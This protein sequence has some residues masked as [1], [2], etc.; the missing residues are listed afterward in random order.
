[1]I[2]S[3]DLPPSYR[4]VLVRLAQLTDAEAGEV[5]DAL[6][7]TAPL[8]DRDRLLD[9]LDATS[10]FADDGAGGV[11]DAL[12]GIHGLRSA[13]GWGIDETARA[14][15]WSLDDLDDAA[16][17][18]LVAR[19]VRAL[20]SEGLLLTSK[21]LDV[22]TDHDRVYLEAR[23]LTDLRPVFLDDPTSGIQA[24]VIVHTLRINHLVDGAEASFYVA[25]DEAD[26]EDLQ[27]TLDR[28][29]EKA[30]HLRGFAA[31]A[32][33]DLYQPIPSEGAA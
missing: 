13:E 2:S 27:G 7:G 19:L 29:V 4:R 9:A 6:N 17:S 8:A 28:A 26:L 12:I 23:I 31:Q 15:A 33:L 10:P 18:R 32:E 22:L 16:R 11:V 30:D 1:M 3:V 21:A 20:E 5:I 24:G 14:I 25:L